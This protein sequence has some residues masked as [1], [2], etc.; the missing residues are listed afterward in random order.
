M[1]V[2]PMVETLTRQ[3]TIE[4]LNKNNPVEDVL[5]RFEDASN[6]QDP[7][8]QAF[9]RQTAHTIYDNLTY[10][11]LHSERYG[12]LEHPFSMTL[13]HGRT[14]LFNGKEFIPSED[15]IRK[16]LE[17]FKVLQPGESIDSLRD[18][19]DLDHTRNYPL[20]NSLP[21]EEKRYHDI[22]R[23][24][25][26]DVDGVSLVFFPQLNKIIAEVETGKLDK[27]IKPAAIDPH[28][29]R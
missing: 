7:I 4:D 6:H 18:R 1:A 9:V 29:F 16:I 15:F 25:P 23:K 19:R 26:T 2:D 5:A 28:L 8:E 14:K 11:Q 24:I 20:Y 12:P 22:I 3:D 17:K 13:V 21:D 27:R 10:T